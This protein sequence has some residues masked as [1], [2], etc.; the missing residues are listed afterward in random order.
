M[1][2]LPFI[3]MN[4]TQAAKFREETAAD[5]NRLDPRLVDAGEFAGKFVLPEA[6]LFDP[7]HEARRDALRTLN[8]AVIDTDTAWPPIGD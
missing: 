1:P 5:E 3:V 8:I 4:A 6:V 7:A 2:Q